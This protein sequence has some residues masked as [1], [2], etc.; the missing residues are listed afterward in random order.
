MTETRIEYRIIGR[1]RKDTKKHVV[2]YNRKWTYEDALNRLHEVK[3][4]AE[5]ETA[6]KQRR[7]QQVGSF[8]VSTEYYSDYD[9]LDLEIQSR[10]VT[11]WS[12]CN[13]ED[14]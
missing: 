7:V 8:G 14:Y 2:D 11:K 13:E 12:T 3:K 1:F 10:E 6:H 9:L 4:Q 5:L